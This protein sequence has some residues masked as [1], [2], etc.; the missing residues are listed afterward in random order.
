MIKD[1]AG[2]QQRVDVKDVVFDAV[3]GGMVS[4]LRRYEAQLRRAPN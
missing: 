3:V 4:S 2:M 1:R